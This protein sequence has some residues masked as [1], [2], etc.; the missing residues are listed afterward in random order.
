MTHINLEEQKLWNNSEIW[1]DN[2]DTKFWSLNFP[3][4]Q[5]LWFDLLKDIYVPHLGP[6]T[7]EIAPG[8]GRIS[9][10]F[11]NYTDSLSLVEYN[12][13][14]LKFCMDR[15]GTKI[16][17]YHLNN[18]ESLSCFSD[19]TFDSI[20]SFDSFVHIHWDIFIKYLSEIHRVL[21]KGGKATIHHAWF[22]GGED[23]S[24]SNR[25][26]RANLDPEKLNNFL[27]DLDF[28]ILQQVSC[29]VSPGT[30]DLITTFQK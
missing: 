27:T 5:S 6:K 2:Y 29:I 8:S 25:G 7:L 4:V 11:L 22:Y 14:P 28:K 10:F 18:G 23:L 24:F 12:P 3:S 30:T 21:N 26:G 16:Q 19:S 17:G 13:V 15:F 1:E 20:V 9:E